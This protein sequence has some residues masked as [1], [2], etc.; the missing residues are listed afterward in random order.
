[1]GLYRVR[2]VDL[3]MMFIDIEKA[4]DRVPRDVLW[5]YLEKTGVSLV[6]IRV[7]KDMYQGVG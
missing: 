7:I 6:Y 2:K 4:H 3:H 1:M 5:S